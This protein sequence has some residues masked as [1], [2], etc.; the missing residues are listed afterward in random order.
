MK[1]VKYSSRST[2]YTIQRERDYNAF[3]S[4]VNACTPAQWVGIELHIA[5]VDSRVDHHPR[6]SSQLSVRRNVDY[7]RLFVLPQAINYV[8]SKLQYLVV[9]VYKDT[10]AAIRLTR[11]YSNKKETII[12]VLNL[13]KLIIYV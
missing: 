6:P 10:K 5:L 9:H 3:V 8:C 12:I 13:Q 4:T 1:G 2:T 11:K 7:N